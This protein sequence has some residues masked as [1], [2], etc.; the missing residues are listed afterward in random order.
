M[1]ARSPQVPASHKRNKVLIRACLGVNIFSPIFNSEALKTRYLGEFD[2]INFE[3]NIHPMSSFHV[4]LKLLSRPY[5]HMHIT[6]VQGLLVFNF[7]SD[8]LPP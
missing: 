3:K 1:N 6:L 2:L 7:K 4:L 8:G 5:L